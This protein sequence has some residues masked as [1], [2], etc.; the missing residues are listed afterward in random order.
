MFERE[1]D[2]TS[3][4]RRMEMSGQRYADLRPLV[5]AESAPSREGTGRAASPEHS[6]DTI[7]AKTGRR[8]DEWVALIDAGPGRAAGHAAIA[9][10]VTEEHGVDGW[11]A[12]GVTVGYERLTG[13]RLPGQMPDGTFSVSRSKTLGLEWVQLRELLANPQGRAALLPAMTS[14]ERSRPGVRAPKFSLSD[15]DTGAALGVL[16][17]RGEPANT[18]CRLV[19]THEK[20]PGPDVAEAWKQF[21][22]AWLEELA[23]AS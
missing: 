2:L 10:W 14:N 1:P 22:S 12:Q 6:D 7:R 23:T 9:A 13:L 4:R 20:L 15:P 5:L 11:W 16:Q 17:F 21:W 8:W 19:V 18:G 3:I